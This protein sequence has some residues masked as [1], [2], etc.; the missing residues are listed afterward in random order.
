M[1]TEMTQRDERVLV[2]WAYNL[3]D[4]IPHCRDFEDKLIKLVWNQRPS[5]LGS[6]AS[7]AV[8]S[9]A[10]SEQNLTEKATQI[11]AEKEAAA[12]EKEAVSKRE[13][14]KKSRRLFGLSYFVSNKEDVEQNAEGPS[15]RPM[16]LF[17]P[18]YGGLTVALAICEYSVAVPELTVLSV[19]ASF[20][21]R[22]QRCQCAHLRKRSGRYLRTL[23]T[24]RHGPVLVLRL[25]GEYPDPHSTIT[26]AAYIFVIV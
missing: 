4:I 16:R 6:L 15:Y 20:S 5:V 24:A 23:C 12:K 26:T 17:A 18:F 13:P 1:L 19:S 8:P 25:S 7:S 10:G 11:V 2:V 22:W 21:L 3:D 9:A 14:P